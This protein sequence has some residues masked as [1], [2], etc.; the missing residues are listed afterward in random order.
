MFQGTV[1]FRL[2]SALGVICAV[3]NLIGYEIQEVQ[4]VVL[5]A[6]TEIAWVPYQVG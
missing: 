5:Q 1:I 4:Q 6:L 3:I 2:T